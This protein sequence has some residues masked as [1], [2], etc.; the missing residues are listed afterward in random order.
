MSI[1]EKLKILRSW[2][3]KYERHLSSLALLIGFVID[4]LTLTRID[5]W[6]D[7]LILF[8]YLALSF[9]GIILI[10][11]YKDSIPSNKILAQLAIY[12]P[13]LV[14]FAFG[15]LF[16]G[17]VIFYV[18]GASIS[19]S[20][21]F[22][23]I[24]LGLLIGNEFLRDKYHRLVFQLNVFF[25]ALFSFLI[26]YVP[27]VV[28]E[29]GV[30]VFILSGILSISLMRGVIYLLQLIT[31][32]Q[33]YHNKKR[34]FLSILGVFFVINLF[35]FLNIIPPLPLSLKQIGV[36]HY[37]EREDSTG[38]V[39][40][41]EEESWCEK[42]LSGREIHIKEGEPLY[43]FSSIFA[44]TKLETEVAHKWYYYDPQV[45]EWKDRACIEYPIVGGR[46]E[47]YRGYT[48]NKNLRE[49]KWRVDVISAD[50][51]LIGRINFGIEMVDK[52]PNLETIYK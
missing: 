38:Y 24:L 51:R 31:P 45:D 28:G 10:N 20:W 32:L 52:A 14:Q 27:I 33:I 17:L 1:R 18:R 16:S 49:G 34:I 11:F 37:V 44:P 5:L 12:S 19:V 36:Y 47:G 21:P 22:I 7:N 15:G 42:F 6:L 41:K 35:Y 4:N 50:G 43:V 13:L 2:Y 3:E 26:F 25:I 8:S 9:L 39:L 48:F 40:K 23:L 46:N 29:M 30:F